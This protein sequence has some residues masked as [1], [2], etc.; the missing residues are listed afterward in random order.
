MNDLQPNRENFEQAKNTLKSI[1]ENL[2]FTC[3]L[4]TFEEESFFG[5][6][7]KSVTGA[8]MNKFVKQIQRV[9]IDSNAS[10]FRL[11]NEFK[12]IYNVIEALDNEYLKYFQSSID[13]LIAVNNEVQDA[14]KDVASTLIVLKA[15]I[16]KLNEFKTT[17][18]SKIINLDDRISSFEKNIKAKLDD[19]EKIEELKASLDN[20]EHF[21]DIDKTWEDVQQH[22]L[23]IEKL[24]NLTKLISYDLTVIKNHIKQIEQLKH[25]N[26]I[27][28]T[29][30]QVQKQGS[31]INSVIDNLESL[32]SLKSKIESIVHFFEVDEMWNDLEE[33]KSDFPNIYSKLD[34]HTKQV[35]SLNAH[36]EQINSITHL[37]DI[38][39]LWDE[40]QSLKLEMIDAKKK[41]QELEHKTNKSILELVEKN[42]VLEAVIRDNE[43]KSDKK[44]T[45]AYIIG[46]LA[47]LMVLIQF[48]LNFSK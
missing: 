39:Q 13:N 4:N 32:N 15:T 25:I 29:W 12:Q 11:F 2:P 41:H 30:E 24:L 26:D 46:G 40:N 37:M 33:I 21:I 9:I 3:S 48:A 38:D 27:D 19:L 36:K 17:T 1:S 8:E 35:Q 42:E 6:M 10:V 47:F 16:E 23:E 43:I 44:V 5:L 7:S 14:Q 22:K 31:E 28:Q 34:E 18:T 45:F 20:Y